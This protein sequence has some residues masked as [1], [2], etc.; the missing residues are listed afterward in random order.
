MSPVARIEPDYSA[1]P[2]AERRT[3]CPTCKERVDE[4]FLRSVPEWLVD[5]AAPDP[6]ASAVGR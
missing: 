2:E 1:L 3:V 6:Y 4:D 5:A